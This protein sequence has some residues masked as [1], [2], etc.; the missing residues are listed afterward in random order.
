[1]RARDRQL[2]QGIGEHPDII[3]R[4][5]SGIGRRGEESVAAAARALVSSDQTPMA[6][7]VDGKVGSGLI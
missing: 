2:A 6:Q 1:M 4:S 5:G 7:A 3:E